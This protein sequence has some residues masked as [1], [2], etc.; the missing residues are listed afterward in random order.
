MLLGQL[1]VFV[2][3]DFDDHFGDDLGSDSDY[4]FDFYEDTSFDC[5]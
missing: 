4:A 1:N 2:K 3:I 5:V